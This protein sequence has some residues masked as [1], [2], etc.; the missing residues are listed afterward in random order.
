MLA[1]MPVLN[2]QNSF[3]NAA[4]A[5]E[6]D[7][8]DDNKYTQYPTKENKYECKTGPF[9]G[10][11]VSSVE[12]CDAK[13]KFKDKDRDRDDNRTGPQGPPGPQGPIGPA[14]PAGANG[15]QGPPGPQG[16]P[17]I[18]GS[19]ATGFTCVTCLLD[20]LAKLETGAVAVNVSASLPGTLFN[21]PVR[22]LVSLSLPLTIDLDT[23]TLLQAQLG[24]SLGVGANA[25]IFE[26]CAAIDAGTVLDINAV[27]AA[28]DATILPLVTAEI[29]SQITN[30]AQVLN[31]TGVIVPAPLL[32]AILAGINFAAI[33]DEIGVDIRASL[34]IL[35]ECLSLAPPPPIGTETLT[36]IKNVDCQA[37]AQT[38]E[39]NPIQ[40]SNFTI[41]IDGNNPSQNNF[42]G[43]SGT[44]THV[45]LEPGAYNVTEQGLDL[46]TPAICSTL[47]FE[48]GSTLGDGFFICT[49]FSDNGCDGD[50]TIGNPQTCTIDNAL[51]K[52]NF[53]DLA[54]ANQI[55]NDVSILIG[56]GNGTFV[57][58]AVNYGV[59]GG[60]TSVAVGDYNND[61]ILDLAVADANSGTVS[62]LIG[63]GNGTFVTPAVS[64]RVEGAPF[65]VAAGDFN[66]DKILD[67]ATANAISDDV[68]I[69]IGNGNGT[70]VPP[71]V[72]YGVGDRPLS[73]AVGDFNNDTILDLATANENSGTVSILI[74]NGNGTFVDTPAVSYRVGDLPQSV[75][76]GDFNNDKNLDLAVAN[77]NTNNVSILLGT[78]TGSFI[79][80]AL[81][82]EVG[83]GPF[84]VAVGD[85]NNDTNLD[86]ATANFFSND[87]SILIGNG[88]GTFVTPAVNFGVGVR[89][90]SV[91]VG[92]F[93]GDTIQD[94][95]VAN[96]ISDNVS[97]LIG[98]G[99]GT[100]VT[101]A[102]NFGVGDGPRFVAVGEF[103][104]KIDNS[105]QPNQ[106]FTNEISETG[107]NRD[108]LFSNEI[109]SSEH[110]MKTQSLPTGPLIYDM[111]KH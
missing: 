78:D 20:A 64:Y 56:N 77:R 87:V 98:N 67:L 40:P 89:P 73:I 105:Q 58:P 102:L 81:N 103:N 36:V 71:A 109:S 12:F 27:L 9:E 7:N 59:G 30:I 38:C 16:P 28:L 86:L 11:F 47:G 33:V 83:G 5:Q 111:P 66:N 63:K 14:G 21:P 44:G 22:G 17:G 104:S 24:K 46:V 101:P 70:F 79:I 65:S 100:F 53:L 15:T 37:D 34:E 108:Q 91:A 52:L 82:F 42:T 68:S 55:S 35:E 95:A 18:N 60:E 88:N 90:F 45:E 51:A 50:I 62:I 94:L 3:S 72:K 48:A 61:T 57:T 10:F 69:L 110:K 29:T 93:N 107:N 43:S 85:F 32:T 80:P 84:S 99:N 2:Q 23:A 39:Q 1:V 6:Y 75:A 41:V 26:I 19:N 97:I 31:A 54:V 96:F 74:G 4:M 76:V 13:H 8:Y 25:T 92:D 106:L 49:H